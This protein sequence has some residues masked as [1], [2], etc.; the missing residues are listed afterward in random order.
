MLLGSARSACALVVATAFVTA[1]GACGKDELSARA[2]GPL[3][4][5]SKAEY[6]ARADAVCG[7]ANRRAS[8]LRA[9]DF[10][11]ARRDRAVLRAAAGYLAAS[12]V[13]G[14]WELDRIYSLGPIDVDDDL[15]YRALAA[16]D[17][18]V[19]GLLTVANDAMLADVEAFRADFAML[20]AVTRRAGALASK[21]GYKVCGRGGIHR[22]L[23][24]GR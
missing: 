2:R 1:V 23:R 7:A 6:L 15:H 8:R 4:L 20:H 3:T 13:I 22:V 9:P 21:L 19:S 24:S 16:A 18:I 12:A 14:R 11:R 5:I 17:P 10:V